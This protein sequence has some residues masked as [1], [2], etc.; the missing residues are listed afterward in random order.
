MDNK[1]ASLAIAAVVLNVMRPLVHGAYGGMT[2]LAPT[3]AVLAS[4]TPTMPFAPTRTASAP[5]GSSWVLSR[6]LSLTL[7]L[8]LSFPS[9]LFVFALTPLF[10]CCFAVNPNVKAILRGVGSHH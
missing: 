10:L 8:L 4:I 1:E 6:D 2:K 5:Q 7:V 3:T 9:T